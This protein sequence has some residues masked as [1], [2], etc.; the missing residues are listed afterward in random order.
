MH[1]LRE[2]PAEALAQAEPAL[3]GEA[4]RRVRAGQVIRQPGYDGEYGTIRVFQPGEMDELRRQG[5]LLRVAATPVP[6]RWA[7]VAPPPSGPGT[8]A[9]Y[10]LGTVAPVVSPEVCEGGPL[11]PPTA[12]EEA[13]GQLS[14]F[15]GPGVLAGLNPE[16]RRAAAAAG[17][18]VV[19]VA[20]PGT[21][22]TRTLTH[23]IAHLVVDRAVAPETILAV[24]FTN[25]AATELRERLRGLL[26]ERADAIATGTFHALCLQWLRRRDPWTASACL[27]D[28]DQERELMAA[29]LR[30]AAAD[31]E[32]L[33]R[34]LAVRRREAPTN[35]TPPA[36]VRLWE[37]T[38]QERGLLPLDALI[39]R[40][41]AWLRDDPEARRSL[42]FAWICVDEFQDINPAQYE[43]V[44]ELA[45]DGHGLCVIGDPDQ[46][47]YGFR[48]ADARCFAVLCREMPAAQVFRLS[49]NFRSAGLLVAAASAVMAPGRTE[50]SV[51]PAAATPG[52]LAVRLHA[53]PSVAA[54]AEFIAHEIEQWLGGTAHFSIDSGRV[55]ETPGGG[56]ATFGDMAVL[57]RLKALVPAYAEALSRLGVPLQTAGGEDPLDSP[58]IRKLLAVL[59]DRPRA[60]LSQPAVSALLEPAAASLLTAAE[61]RALE[62]LLCPAAGAPVT[63]A[64]LLDRILLRVPGDEV[65]VHAERVALLTMHAAKGLEFPIVFVAGCEDGIVP[66][67][68]DGEAADEAEERRLLYV[69]MT[70]A[71]QV[72]YLTR[73]RRRVLFGRRGE[74]SPSPFLSALPTELVQTLEPPRRARPGGGGVQ[75]EFDLG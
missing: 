43:L 32:C 40:C 28:D 49:C 38:L 69:A 18:P 44:R 41:L 21:G 19:I 62:P 16:Q 11:A 34:D 37:T 60:A 23:R 72:L 65:Q 70:R 73:S 36:T 33:Q 20:G 22:K 55:S 6:A 13:S 30:L 26:G 68:R 54:E 8:D 53:A 58:G 39:P 5:L 74:A 24:T 1:I 9:L 15:G 31:L 61:R 29:G 75:L 10:R 47:I 52:G 42:G 14:L 57:V 4:I 50:L 45:G 35:T 66:Y 59:R 12:R 63:L 2:L 46:S 25:R 67:R 71:R 64:D 7:P 56:A 27:I 48:G 3:L 17:G 51:A